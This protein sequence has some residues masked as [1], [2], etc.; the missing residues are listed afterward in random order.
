MTYTYRISEIPNLTL[1]FLLEW[2]MIA[3]KKGERQFER[4]FLLLLDEK[5]KRNEQEA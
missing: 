4:L 3:V 1:Q 5:L 2:S